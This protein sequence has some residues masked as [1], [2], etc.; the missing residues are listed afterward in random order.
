MNWDISILKSE[1]LVS[2]KTNGSFDFAQ[3]MQMTKET[4]N[5][6]S[7]NGISKVLGDHLDLD[8][9]VSIFEIF[10]IPR[11]LLKEGVKAPEKVA[12][13]YDEA[14]S[15]AKDFR[16]FETTARNVGMQT[17]LFTNL[18]DARAW[19]EHSKPLA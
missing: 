6:A 7:E 12:V 11:E 18:E 8:P 4:F 9:N 5:A 15:K 17:Q 14:S 3:I 19:L 13:V 10:E 1:D 16:L 2:V